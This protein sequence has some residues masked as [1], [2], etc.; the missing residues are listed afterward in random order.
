[1]VMALVR[2]GVAMTQQVFQA[3]QGEASLQC[4]CRSCQR[5]AGRAACLWLQV[6]QGVEV[7]TG[8]ARHQ[9]LILWL[10]YQAREA[11]VLAESMAA[12]LAVQ[13]AHQA[14]EPVDGQH[15]RLLARA[16]GQA[17]QGANLTDLYHQLTPASG[18]GVAQD[19]WARGQTG[20]V[21]RL[22]LAAHHW[23]WAAK[24]SALAA[25][26]LEESL[27]VAAPG[28]VD[29]QQPAMLVAALPWQGLASRY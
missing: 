12:R 14:I 10:V 7:P 26:P 24:Q 27:E 2:L 22:G 1:M 18:C 8:V 17:A 19:S 13:A 9:K 16:Q 28:A 11:R 29:A 6:R 15:R 25:H 5:V 3:E 4:C 20:G 23:A 21:H